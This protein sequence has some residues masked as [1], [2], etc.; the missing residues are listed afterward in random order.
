[1]QQR[2]EVTKP[3]RQLMFSKVMNKGVKRAVKLRLDVMLEEEERAFASWLDRCKRLL[4]KTRQQQIERNYLKRISAL[5]IVCWML[6][7]MGDRGDLPAMVIKRP[8]ELKPKKEPK[9]LPASDQQPPVI[10]QDALNMLE[11]LASLLKPKTA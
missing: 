5:R 8:K 7:E 11:S 1:M 3:L 2:D 10:S 4:Q 9:L 6:S